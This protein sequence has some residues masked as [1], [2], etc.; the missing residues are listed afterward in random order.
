MMTIS[1]SPRSIPGLRVV[2]LG[3][4]AV[5]IG[6]YLFFKTHSVDVDNH[7]RI[8]DRL[9]HLHHLEGVFNEEILRLRFD[10]SESHHEAMGTLA[11]LHQ[12]HQELMKGPY[13]IY[14][15]GWSDVNQ[16][17]DV[18]GQVLKQQEILF[19][20]FVASPAQDLDFLIKALL[21][22]PN[23]QSLDAIDETYKALG[24][25]R[26]SPRAVIPRSA[27]CQPMKLFCCHPTA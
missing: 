11:Q 21:Q 14:H 12:I 8:T 2:L 7:Y 18:Y 5:S 9:Q 24:E 3:I 22:L 20:Q 13:S 10:L 17:M 23:T 15:Q 4:V 27:S 25:K 6:T 19:R 26:K 1:N 16:F